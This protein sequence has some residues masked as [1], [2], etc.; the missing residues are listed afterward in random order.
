MVDLVFVT[1]NF[2]NFFTDMLELP[3]LSKLKCT[4]SH[5]RQIKT[6][7]FISEADIDAGVHSS[8]LRHLIQKGVKN[9]LLPEAKPFT[10]MDQVS[11]MSTSEMEQIFLKFSGRGSDMI[12]SDLSTYL[13]QMCHDNIFVNV[14]DLQ[15]TVHIRGS[16]RLYAADE[17]PVPTLRS[18]NAYSMVVHGSAV[19]ENIH[20]DGWAHKDRNECLL[21]LGSAHFDTCILQS[22]TNNGNASMKNCIIEP[23]SHSQKT[24][25]D[26]SWM[27]GTGNFFL[28]SLIELFFDST[29]KRQISCRNDWSFYRN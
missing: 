18:D 10:T 29:M 15:D 1:D 24:H 4:N 7:D 12:P 19:F 27:Q 11:K 6:R 3:V 21:I 2:G 28:H 5:F 17:S 16:V 22:L 8:V 14:Y 13:E 25:T 9:I 23:F 20:F 26:A